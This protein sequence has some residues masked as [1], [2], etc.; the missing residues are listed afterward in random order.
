MLL[1]RNNVA[2]VFTSQAWGLKDGAEDLVAIYPTGVGAEMQT[3]FS[4]F[5]LSSDDEVVKSFRG[6]FDGVVKLN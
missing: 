6:L 1:T 3:L 2:G 5:M 4:M